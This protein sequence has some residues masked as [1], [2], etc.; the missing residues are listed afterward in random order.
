MSE[1]SWVLQGVDAQIRQRAIEQTERLGVP[2]ADYLTEVVLKAAVQEQ[3]P[4]TAPLPGEAA[5]SRDALAPRRL[6]AL[7]R[8]VGLAVGGLDKAVRGLEGRVDEAEARTADSA[9]RLNQ[10]LQ[11]AGAHF[12]ALHTRLNSVEE[13]AASRLSAGL[14][15][16]RAAGD[17]AAEQA[18]AAISRLVED[19][20]AVREAVEA[21]LRESASETRLRIQAAFADIG[22]R[23]HSLGERVTGCERLVVRHVEQMRV[24]I[25]DLEAQTARNQDALRA[26][27]AEAQ[28]NWDARFE[29]LVARQANAERDA[30]ESHRTLRADNERV[31]E[32]A[33]AH[34]AKDAALH[35]ELD[36]IRDDTSGALARLSLLD[37][38][39]GARSLMAALDAGH[40]PLADRV[41]QLEAALAAQGAARPTDDAIDQRLHRLEAAADSEENAHALAALR[42][43]IAALA[44]RLDVQ[45]IGEAEDLRP[46]ILAGQDASRLQ[47]IRDVEQRIRAFEERQ[48]AAIQRLH[49][50]IARFVDAQA[51]RLEAV[52]QA[53][54]QPQDLDLAAEF[55][56]LRRRVEERILGAEERSVRALEQ[57]AGAMAVLE[58]R[59]HAAPEEIRQRA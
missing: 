18:D 29:A 51:R 31:A 53:A 2:L 46:E 37:R 7:E 41:A 33:H 23:T 25:A 35:R 28:S 12:A 15:E 36:D 49:G 13:Q 19:L 27:Q 3:P 10:T 4:E 20:R 22:Q 9:E 32:L 54:S 24:Q 55:A 40:A 5:P 26:A 42:G 14:D 17:A 38:A 6:E 59:L 30:A 8:R 39:I 45:R 43:Q 44:A 48:D 16:I 1:T 34:A 47:T 57:A 11:E 52:E 56:I 58:Q 21:R 50:D